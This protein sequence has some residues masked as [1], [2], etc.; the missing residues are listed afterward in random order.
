[1]SR[2]RGID[3]LKGIGCIIIAFMWHYRHFGVPM[4]LRIERSSLIIC[5]ILRMG[6]E[7]G[8]IMVELFF[9]MSGYVIAFR[10]K[11]RI[12]N[13]LSF[14]DYIERRLSVLWPPMIITLLCVTL[15]E[16]IYRGCFGEY[17]VYKQFGLKKF[18]LNM[19]MID[20]E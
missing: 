14:R 17:F 1:M 12:I 8:W 20:L 19:F 3:Y 5:R 16:Y 13:K 18:L 7:K 6:F 4:P 15:L 2:N 10:Y 9:I 11:N